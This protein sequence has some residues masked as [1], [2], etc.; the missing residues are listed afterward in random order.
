LTIR[1]CVSVLPE[2]VA[3]ALELVERA[4]NQRADLIEVRIDSLKKHS[5]LADIAGC[6]RVPMIATNRSTKCHG[7][8]RGS[9]TERKRILLNAAENGFE[10]IDIELSTSELEGIVSDVH[11]MG[12]K[13]IVS[14]HGFNQTPSL[15]QMEETLKKEIASGA[16]VC[17][18]V[19]TARSVEDN[20]TVLN[21]VS[22]ACKSAKTVCFSM[23]ELGKISRLL[24]PLF[25]G[26]F[27]F[28][29]LERGRE[30]ASGQLTIQEMR[31]AYAALGL[32]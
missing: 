11:G 27:T 5:G 12:V 29:S 24:S 14:F 15:P 6:G 22:K 21:F 3:E 16:D 9:E 26:F 30:T 20:L 19:T 28:A 32:M 18:V 23:G 10:Y 7:K 1:I 17:K 31:T 8:F 2:T 13:S 25:G 4:E